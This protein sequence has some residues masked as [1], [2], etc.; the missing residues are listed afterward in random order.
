MLAVGPLVAV[1][2]LGLAGLTSF[3]SAGAGTGTEAVAAA[4]PTSAAMTDDTMVES[5]VDL[6][7][8]PAWQSAEIVDV[9]GET[10]RLADYLGTPVLVETFATWCSNC[11]A[12]LGDT[13]EAAATLG[14][15]AAFVILSVET[16]LDPGVVARYA[17]DNGFTGM[18]FAVVSPE[19]LA[20]LV[21]SFGNSIANPPATPKFVIAPDGTVSELVTG[22]ESADALVA[23]LEPLAA[24]ME[25]AAS[26]TIAP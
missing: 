12:Q 3:G 11:R 16:D 21:G 8:L 9:D 13:T 7:S 25:P 15:R 20:E 23:T 26:S 22:A 14:E 10:F 17:T 4:P 6:A 5:S 1:V 24:P 19:L 18:R 2:G